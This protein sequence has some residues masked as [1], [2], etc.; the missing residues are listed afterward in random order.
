VIQANTSV[1]RTDEV[2][3]ARIDARAFG[4]FSVFVG[5]SEDKQNVKVAEDPEEIVVPGAQDG[6]FD[7][8][9]KS[10]DL[11]AKYSA[12]G[13]TLGGD[14]RHDNADDPVV[15]TD[16]L[17][18]DRFRLRAAWAVK[19]VFRL[20]VTA[21]QIDASNDRSGI[22]YDARI[23]QYGGEAE[24]SPATFL[25][26]RISAEEYQS[27]SKILFRHPEDF[28]IDTSLHKEDGSSVEGGLTLVFSPVTIDGA[29]GHFKNNGSFPFTIDRASVRASVDV[30]KN[31][32]IIGEWNRDKYK[33][34]AT[35][36]GSLANYDANRYGIYL[37]WRQ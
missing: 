35:L 10:F 15:R 2:F 23:R 12:S 17:D 7:R 16:F 34:S 24:A 22:G 18:R 14:W 37:R 20:S 13:L 28:S 31:A 6:S 11:G 4:P 21:E 8:K 19:E 36:A 26:L 25:R 9:I 29:A 32:S 30:T 1:E 5:G 3:D 33:E 27:D